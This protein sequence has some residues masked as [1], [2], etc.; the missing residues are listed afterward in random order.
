MDVDEKVKVR[1]WQADGIFLLER[2][3]VIIKNLRRKGCVFMMN[4]K[5]M[6]IVRMEG[7]VTK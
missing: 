5:K 6:E 2:I 3:H 7:G 4:T 1:Q